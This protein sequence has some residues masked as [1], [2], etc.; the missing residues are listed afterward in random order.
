MLGVGSE[1]DSDDQ[2]DIAVSDVEGQE[3]DDLPDARAW[4][5]QKKKFYGA[6]Y[7]DPDYGGF[8][9]KDAH[10]AE[11]EQEEAQ[12]LQN[13]LMAQLDVNFLEAS[14]L[15]KVAKLKL[16]KPAVFERDECLETETRWQ[17]ARWRAAEDRLVQADAQTEVATAEEGVAG[18]FRYCWGS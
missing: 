11:V 7:V 16:R 3:D 12:E 8:Q 14:D 6:D 9:G 17:R 10:A 1:Q 15:F 18:V 5:K 13:Q 4:G 2:S